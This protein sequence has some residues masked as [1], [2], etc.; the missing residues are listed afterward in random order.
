MLVEFKVGNYRSFRDP[1]TLSLVA[2][3]DKELSQNVLTKKGLPLLKGAAI[4]GPN[5][6]GK[7]NVIRAAD[8][9]SRIVLDSASFKPDEELPVQPFAFDEEHATRPTLFEVIFY[10]SGVRYQYGFEATRKRIESEWLIAYPKG[11][12]QKWFERSSTKRGKGYSWKFSSHLR[13]DKHQLTEKTRDNALFLSV[14]AQWNHAQLMA[15]HSWFVRQVRVKPAAFNWLPVT[16]ELL[17]DSGRGKA[18]GR[19][20]ADAVADVLSR[21]DLGICDVFVRKREIKPDRDLPKGLPDEP[22]EKMIAFFER[23]YLVE[24]R[25][26]CMNGGGEVSIPW[27]DESDGTRRFFEMIGPWFQAV[28]NNATAFVD[29]IESSLHPLLTRF[30]IHMIMDA[31]SEEDSPQLIFATHDTTLLDP[32]LLRRDQIWFTEKDEYGA[33][34]LYSMWDYKE[35]KPRKREAMQKGY[36]AGRYGAIPIIEAFDMHNIKAN[37]KRK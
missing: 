14:A 35:H 22:K 36:L 27:E 31:P 19:A 4:Y 20:F 34:H 32:E 1:Q 25:H 18:S 5:A 9:T 17:H 33:T 8:T 3:S 2:S 7:S 23:Q 37:R 21:A 11:R 30:L 13:G 6:S 29:E 24:A 28:V 16:A 15:V 12:P 26:R 10:S